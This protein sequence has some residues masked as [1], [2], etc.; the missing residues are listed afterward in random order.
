M[1]GMVGEGFMR[2]RPT[3]VALL[4]LALPLEVFMLIDAR[5]EWRRYENPFVVRRL[6]PPPQGAP[7]PGARRD[8][9]TQIRV[10]W[11]RSLPL[12]IDVNLV[13]RFINRDSSDDLFKYHRHIVEILATYRY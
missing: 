11:R 1:A 7:P 5:Y 13:Y 10:D 2:S 4:G 6:L 12:N 9:T 8:R 3:L